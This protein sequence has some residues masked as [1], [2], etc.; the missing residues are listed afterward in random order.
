MTASAGTDRPEPFSIL[1]VCTWNLCRSVIA[2]RVA[3]REIQARLGDEA[4]LFHVV[5]AG[6]AGPGGSL[7][8]PDTA[9]VLAWLGADTRGFSSHRLTALDID[10]ADLILS[11][12]Q[13]HRDQVVA[14]RPGASRRT[15]L[16]REF[17]RLAAHASLPGNGP[18]AV[19]RARYVVTEAA[20][21]R[22]RIPY[23][24]PA[25]EEIPDPGPRYEAVLRCARIIDGAV[26]EVL[27]ALFARPGFSMAERRGGADNQRLCPPGRPAT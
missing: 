7:M 19:E 24:E 4:V 25:A 2:E 22:G 6:T 11:A 9:K 27:D 21:L 1:F 26:R 8:H 15:Y 14:L 17:A 12:C 20:R 16:M 5:S 13:E 23:V 18:W 3:C 10:Q